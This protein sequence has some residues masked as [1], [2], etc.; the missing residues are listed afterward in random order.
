M[1]REAEQ[2][3][4]IAIAPGQCVA[5]ARCARQDGLPCVRPDKLRFSLDAFLLEAAQMSQELFGTKIQ[6]YNDQPP[7][8]LTMVGGLLLP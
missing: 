1:E 7:P 5:C 4:S 2:P 8:Y 3:G 6:W